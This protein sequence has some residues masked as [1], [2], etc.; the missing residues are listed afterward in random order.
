MHIQILTQR[1]TII[2]VMSTT[3]G[4]EDTM[5]VVVGTVD[6]MAVAVDTIMRVMEVIIMGVTGVIM[7]EE[8]G[9]VGIMAEEEVMVDTMVAVDM[10]DTVAVED[11]VE[12][13]TA[14]DTMEG[15]DTIL[16]V[17]VRVMLIDTDSS[18]SDTKLGE[19]RQEV[20]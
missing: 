5:V 8:E 10:V 7:E 2:T 6:I 12:A 14:A 1:A 20:V 4:T 18:H 11:T 15:T 9:M 19:Q 17:L 13:A 16:V 3:V